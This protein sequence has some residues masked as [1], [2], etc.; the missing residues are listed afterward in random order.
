MKRSSKVNQKRFNLIYQR[1]LA[2]F[3]TVSVVVVASFTLVKQVEVSF[4]AIYNLESSL[5]IKL[6]LETK[7]DLSDAVVEVTSLYDHYQ[8]TIPL[9]ENQLVFDQLV[10]GRNYEI[11]VKADLGFGIQTIKETRYKLTKEP[12]GH[13]TYL[14]Q[15]GSSLSYSYEVYDYYNRIDG[16]V[17]IRI[18]K[19]NQLIQEGPVPEVFTEGILSGYGY[20]EEINPSETTYQIK[21]EASINHKYVTL[22]EQTIITTTNPSVHGEFYLMDDILNYF[23]YIEDTFESITSPIITVEIYQNN[24]LIQL[25]EHDRD[26]E[27]QIFNE[28]P[29]YT[30]DNYVAR[31]YVSVSNKR[32]LVY[33]QKITRYTEEGI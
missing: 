19:N 1:L 10:V 25:V 8:Q 21:L 23:L 18:Y 7:D 26:T 11:K 29:G 15:F 33:E 9:G 14:E 24:Q 4:L 22:D 13:I 6:N 17:R 12:T 16:H 32:T 31:V 28:L 27:F 20:L 30:K 3:M 5:Y 2:G